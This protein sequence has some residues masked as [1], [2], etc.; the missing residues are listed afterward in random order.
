M[1]SDPKKL[2]GYEILQDEYRLLYILNQMKQLRE[3]ETLSRAQ[4]LKKEKHRR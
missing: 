2:R 4:R 3:N 1:S